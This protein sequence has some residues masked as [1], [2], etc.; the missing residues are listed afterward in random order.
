[1][2]NN[3]TS[4]ASDMNMKLGLKQIAQ[5]IK[6][7]SAIHVV[8]EGCLGIPVAGQVTDITC[9]DKRCVSGWKLIY[10][11]VQ[12]QDFKQRYIGTSLT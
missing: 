5:A 2:D 7:Q 9:Q 6:P 11:T 4:N 10:V 8:C 1:M 3:H 12:N